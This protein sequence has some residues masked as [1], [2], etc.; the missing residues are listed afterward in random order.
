M[1]I[2]ENREG[3]ILSAFVKPNSP[4]FQI[5]LVGK[6]ITIY[7]TQEPVNGKVNKEIIKELSKLFYAKV[8]I[9]SGARSRQ[10]TV[11]L[12]DLNK[13]KVQE[14]LEQANE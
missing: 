11:L 9:T 3:T 12:K 5:V 7:A 8:E 6:E 14:I 10:K 13:K 2:A 4:K 1:S